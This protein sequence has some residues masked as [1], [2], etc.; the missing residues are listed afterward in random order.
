[1]IGA[2]SRRE[3]A[4][5][6][7]E[8]VASIL[9]L[10]PQER[11]LAGPTVDGSGPLGIRFNDLTLIR[12]GASLTG[13][14]GEI[15]PGVIVALELDRRADAELLLL[16]VTGLEEPDSGSIE[17]TLGDNT[18]RSEPLSAQTAFVPARPVLFAGSLLDNISLFD[19]GF[20]PPAREL[21]GEIGLTAIADRLPKG[22]R[23]EV[24]YETLAP[25]PL[26]AIKRT[27]IAR[28]LIRQPG[29]LALQSPGAGWT[30][31]ASPVCSRCSR[32]AAAR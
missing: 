24:G 17:L 1:M 28:A 7:D 20:R 5:A 23:T 21:A 32:P 19:K 22:L 8:Q 10:A 9:A 4:H 16:A 27:A 31:E 13:V 14:S 18:E 30:W 12:P 11:A 26:G 29:L 2:I 6:A 3:V 15:P 25:L